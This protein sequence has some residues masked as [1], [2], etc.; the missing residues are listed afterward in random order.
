MY[1]DTKPLNITRDALKLKIRHDST[2]T[3]TN[4]FLSLISKVWIV[5]T[6]A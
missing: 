3:T 6:Q 5:E 4:N 2:G 1:R